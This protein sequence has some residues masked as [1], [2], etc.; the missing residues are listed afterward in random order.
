MYSVNF[1]NEFSATFID[2]NCTCSQVIGAKQVLE[3]GC[4]SA[5]EVMGLVGSEVL[6]QGGEVLGLATRVCPS[7]QVAHK[8][9]E[10]SN[11]NAEEFFLAH[12]SSW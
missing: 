2:E 3:Q 5:N 8:E 4:L 11:R 1:F 9:E 12:R 7:R 10:T 6:Q